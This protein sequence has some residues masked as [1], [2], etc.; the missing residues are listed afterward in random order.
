MGRLV[1]PLE[2]YYTRTP[3]FNVTTPE[4]RARLEAVKKRL[5]EV[6]DA[7]G[8]DLGRG[9]RVLSLCSGSCIDGIALAEEYGCT[10]TCVDK[11]QWL[12]EAGLAYA[13]EKGLKVEAVVG[14]VENVEELVDGDYDVALLWGSSL[15][16][17]SVWSFDRVASGTLNLLKRGAPLI[18]EQRDTIFE[19]L[20]RLRSSALALEDPPVVEYHAGFDPEKGSLRKLYT[21][22]ASGDMARDEI[23]VWGP[24]LIRYVL[25]K[26]GYTGVRVL[27]PP[28][29]HVVAGFKVQR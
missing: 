29:R 25:E 9:C 27:P 24:W 11:Q 22:L 5:R 10:A 23:Y 16:H 6:L 14:D 21:D 12:L 13:G 20:P 4:G 18:V 19:V 26:N 7:L 3:A 1:D 15:A 2:F 17:L 28:P 8:V